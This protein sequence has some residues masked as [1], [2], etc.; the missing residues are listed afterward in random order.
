MAGIILKSVCT[1][2]LLTSATL[3]ATPAFSQATA[4]SEVQL[5]V[6]PLVEGESLRAIALLRA[7]LDAHRSDPA[8]QINL[9]IA[10]AQAGN[11][12]E[13]RKL[14]EAAMANRDVIELETAD[15]RVIDSR[16]LARLALAML[17]RGEFD[18]ARRGGSQLTLRDE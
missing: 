4:P 14:F 8:L 9:G 10:Y 15:G 16:R 11:I 13:S 7:E 5:A 3:A 2:A 17:E 6:E 12:A 1:A 18:A